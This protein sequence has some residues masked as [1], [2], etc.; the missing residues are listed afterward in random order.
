MITLNKKLIDKY[1]GGLDSDCLKEVKQL[2]LEGA[3]LDPLSG[4]LILDN[5]RLGIFT[6]Y[7]KKDEE[8][9]ED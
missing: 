9:E 2:V 7:F 3:V 6:D 8:E 5:I 1:F 4:E